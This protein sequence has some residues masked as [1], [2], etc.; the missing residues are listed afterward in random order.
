MP[1]K[2]LSVTSESL[3]HLQSK[4]SVQNYWAWQRSWVS[5]GFLPDYCR[6]QSPR[7]SFWFS[8]TKQQIWQALQELAAGGAIRAGLLTP[9]QRAGQRMTESRI[10]GSRNLKHR[11]SSWLCSWMPRCP[12]NPGTCFWSHPELQLLCRELLQPH[13]PEKKV[14]SNSKISAA[15]QRWIER[16]CLFQEGSSPLDHLRGKN[17]QSEILYLKCLQA[18]SPL[19]QMAQYRL[20]FF[21]TGHCLK[22][23][24]D[25]FCT[26][27]IF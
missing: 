15:V 3:I 16:Q 25:T 1:L 20:C 5:W 2:V 26:G 12:G 22:K 13:P 9:Q 27:F 23:Q 17:D 4:Y 8:T 10:C 18:K 19:A 7:F 11:L 24:A 14:Q 21:I 6:L